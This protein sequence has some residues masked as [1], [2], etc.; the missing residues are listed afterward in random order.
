MRD[1]RADHRNLD[2]VLLRVLDA[3]ADGLGDLA[4][5]A[6]AHADVAGAVT[7]YDDRA[8]A[9]ASA[10][11]D[12]FGYSVDLDDTLFER[13]AT[14]VD[15]GQWFLLLEVESALARGVSKRANTAVIAEPGAVE[16][17]ALDAGSSCALGQQPADHLGLIRL[18]GVR[19]AHA[20]LER[21]RSGKRLA[22]A[23]VDDLG[24]DLV[25]RTEDGQARTL[26]R[27]RQRQPNPVVALLAHRMRA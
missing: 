21:R 25:E 15:P 3:F 17:D 10:A 16:D 22:G 19:G 14:R 23:I 13:Q 24:V 5:L 2:Q 9:E 4:R 1:G 11:L 27:A 20:R 8:E 18:R 6:Q 7:D 12:D 26:R